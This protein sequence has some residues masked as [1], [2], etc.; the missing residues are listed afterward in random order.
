MGLRISTNIPSLTAIRNLNFTDVRTQKNL[1][2]LSTGEKISRPEDDPAGLSLSETL[3]ARIRALRQTTVNVGA[4]RNMLNT[5]DSALAEVGRILTDLRRSITFALDATATPEMLAAEQQSVDSSLEA[6]ERIAATTRFGDIPLL[7]GSAAFRVSGISRDGLLEVKPFSVRL[8]PVVEVT[9]F[10][11]EV[12][13]TASQATA[14]AGQAA[15]G[16]ALAVSGGSVTLRLTGPLGSVDFSLAGGATSDDVQSAVNE[17]RGITGVYAADGLLFTE[18]FGFEATL[19]IEQVGGPGAFLGGDPLAP[20]VGGVGGVW[21]D[22]GENALVEMNGLTMSGVGNTLHVNTAFFS[23]DIELNP[24]VNEDPLRGPGSA[25]TFQFSIRRSALTFQFNPAGGESGQLTLGLPGTA[26]ADLGTETVVIGGRTFGGVLET[27]RTGSANDLS[28]NPSN[29]LAVLL[30]AMDDVDRARSLAGGFV[31]G[32]VDPTDRVQAVTLENLQASD[33]D[34]RDADFA[35]EAAELA[36]N[37]V[38]FQAG[39][40]VLAQANAVPRSVLELLK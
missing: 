32:V 36:R 21:F 17:S 6:L 11:I 25:G 23:G 29:A 38:L 15:S 33:S 20:G 7:D 1:E 18:S 19:R 31:A 2:R 10:E 28:T 3:R 12:T 8:N 27:L 39:V 22:R 14:L 40:S 9:S 30:S 26:P 16:A 34:L 5:A 4:A 24:A 35:A 37:Q 13:R